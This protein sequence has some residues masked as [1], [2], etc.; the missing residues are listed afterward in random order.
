MVNIKYY[1]NDDNKYNHQKRHNN[2]ARVS[3]SKFKS[4][5]Q[6]DVII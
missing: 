2:L 4:F 6:D 1:H 3:S 5:E